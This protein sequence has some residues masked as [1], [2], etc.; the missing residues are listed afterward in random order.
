[1]KLLSKYTL[2]LGIILLAACGG[3]DTVKTVVPPPQPKPEWVSTRPANSS[4]YIGIATCSKTTQ[5]ADYQAIAKKLALN[6]LATEISVKVEGQTFF[7]TMEVNKAFS[8]SFSSNVSTSSS[9]LLEDY[10]VAGIWEDKELYAIYY[11]LNKFDYQSK[12]ALKK[13]N[14]LRSALDFLKKGREAKK[15][16]NIP[17]AIDLFY[18]GLFALKPY[19]TEVNQ[20]KDE[21]GND[22]F[23]DNELFSEIRAV[24][25][26]LRFE[27]PLKNIVLSSSNT[28]KAQVPVMITYK[29]EGVRGINV[30]YSYQR[31][32]Y[33][34][35][36][37]VMSDN[38]GIILADID[39]V[40]LK[41]KNNSLELS[42][43]IDALV[44]QD[45]DSD[46][47]AAIITGINTDQRKIPIEILAPS[48]FVSSNE[49][50]LS[51]TKTTT[52]AEITRNTL[53]SKGMRI[54]TSENSADYVVY[55][56]TN[57]RA[58]E[59]I[60]GFKVGYLDG[61]ITVTDTKTTSAIFEYSISGV[62]GVQLSHENAVLEAYKKV[63]ENIET[64]QVSEIIKIIL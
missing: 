62:K 39:N 47:A 1:M 2:F 13:E 32:N 17:S 27:T 42:I 24:L 52:L 64:V 41:A 35:P 8:E 37:T 14:T 20:M 46:L 43:V 49:F 19:W 53:I 50:Q 12:K 18:H 58:G 40:S 51:G 36:K 61:K 15:L 22:I 7:N 9:E 29:G 10:E 55:I 5:P 30:R 63:R 3:K 60:Q 59:D 26:D 44:P 54:A 31:D 38:D 45:L 57:P 4:Y 16:G 25:A 48:F 56:N 23:I 28:F 21:N 34:K 6:D 11:K 33:M